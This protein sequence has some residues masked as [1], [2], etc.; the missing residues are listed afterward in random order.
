MSRPIAASRTS[1]NFTVRPASMIEPARRGRD[2][3]HGAPTRFGRGSRRRRAARRAPL[4]EGEPERRRGARPLAALPDARRQ[5]EERQE[6]ARADHAA[7]QAR[8]GRASRASC[9]VVPLGV[10]CAATRS[11]AQTRTRATSRPPKIAAM[12]AT[13]LPDPLPVRE[14]PG[15]HSEQWLRHPLDHGAHRPTSRP[16]PERRGC[17]HGHGCS[18]PRVIRE[19]AS[20][21]ARSG[22]PASARLDYGP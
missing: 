3:A 16:T 14:A 11:A 10:E 7:E 5:I 9:F 1:T 19:R 6:R 21:C 15:A 12:S 2:A 18:K 8:S 13:K 17:A 22:L 4:V 20:V